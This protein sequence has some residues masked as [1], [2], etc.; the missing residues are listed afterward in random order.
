MSDPCRRALVISLHDVSPRT[1]PACAR[2]L[3]ELVDLGARRVSLLVIPD[4]HRRGPF[5]AD[6]EFCAWLVAKAGEGHEIVTHGYYHQRAR[7]AGETALQKLT[8]RVYTADEGE[9]YDLD[10]ETARELVA[11]GNAEL[12][13]AGLEPHGF[14]APAWLLSAEAEAALGELGMDYTTRLGTVSDLQTRRVWKS[15]S[16]VWSVRSGWRRAVSV[17]WNAALY[18]ALCGNPLLRISIHP[19]DVAHP[20]VWRQIRKLVARALVDREPLTYHAWVTG[21]RALD[22]SPAPSS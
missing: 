18:R 20:R 2:I 15:Q 7:R 16:L 1:R 12:T 17:A 3:G 14:V 13:G 10:R 5:L 6:G 9:F 11:R 19:V 4:H 22:L 8:T 21:Q